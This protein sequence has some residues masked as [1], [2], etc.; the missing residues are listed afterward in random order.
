MIRPTSSVPTGPAGRRVPRTARRPLDRHGQRRMP[1]STRADADRLD[2][3]PR[4]NPTPT[5]RGDSTASV[6]LRYAP[7]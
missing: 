7:T 1:L 2:Q 6:I 3:P 4:C 5:N